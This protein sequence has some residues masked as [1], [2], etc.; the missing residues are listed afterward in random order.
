MQPCSFT[1]YCK[2]E[3]ADTRIPDRLISALTDA[4]FLQDS[5]NPYI[6]FVFG[7][8]GAFLYTMA[9]RGFSGNFLLVNSGHLGFFSDYGI[10]EV[11]RLVEDM[12][13]SELRLENVPL[14]EISAS[15]ERYYAAGDISLQSNR[16]SLFTLY[17]NNEEFTSSMASGIVVGNRIGSTGFLAS[18]GAPAI[19]SSDDIYEYVFNAPVR[20]RLYPSTVEKGI[21]SS[22][23]RLEIEI[24][25]DGGL[26]LQVDGRKKD[27]DSN[28]IGIRLVPRTECCI[29]HFDEKENIARIKRQ[30]TV[31]EE[32]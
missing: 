23:D 10:G 24:V 16:T 4:G 13:E 15:G 20:N 3:T 22:K 1:V 27:L 14:L 28:T 25:E 26:L 5:E 9:E 12:I 17:V 18:L 7:G 2:K 31:K 30:M 21:L 32:N 6:T 11:D 29:A 8:D 19:L